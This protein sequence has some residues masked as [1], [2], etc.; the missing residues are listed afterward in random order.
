MKWYNAHKV[1]S[2]V[3][4]T[5]HILFISDIIILITTADWKRFSRCGLSSSLCDS[6]KVLRIIIVPYF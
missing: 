4:G 1:S 3:L 2:I 6:Y 5:Q